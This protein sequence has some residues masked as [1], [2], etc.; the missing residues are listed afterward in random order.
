MRPADNLYPLTFKPAA[1]SLKSTGHLSSIW[2]E[3]VDIQEL[4]FRQLR[5][6]IFDGP[7]SDPTLGPFT[8]STY[9]VVRLTDASGAVG[10]CEFPTVSLRTLREVFVPTLLDTG[11][12][13][14]Q[15]LYTLLYWRIRNQGFR[16]GAAMVLG[17]LDRIFYDL[18]ARRAGMAVHRYLGGQKTH[19]GIYAS[20]GSSHYDEHRL[21]D[22][23]QRWESEGYRTVKMKFGG[24]GWAWPPRY[25][26]FR[27]RA[28]P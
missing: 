15:E 24:W 20:G 21:I 23:L 12:A 19:V 14:Y 3:P 9:S 26:G 16:G 18:V 27:P 28:R 1:Q 7:F 22:E 13:T 2:S 11:P 17:H 4:R 5:P 10:E 25:T 8:Q 6:I